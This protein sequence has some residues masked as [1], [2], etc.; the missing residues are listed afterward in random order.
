MPQRRILLV[1][2]DSLLLAKHAELLASAGFVVTPAASLPE[3]AHYFRDGEFDYVLLCL[4]IP[5][6]D[7]ARF[8]ALIKASGARAHVFTL[9]TYLPSSRSHVDYSHADGLPLV[10]LERLLS[11]ED[12]KRASV[13]RKVA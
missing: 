6:K 5:A 8:N 7:R 2:L 10:T 11:R 9:E 13:L 3:A 1:S 4:S 12:S